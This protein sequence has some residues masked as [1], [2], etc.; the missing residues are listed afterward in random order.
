MQTFALFTHHGSRTNCKQLNGASA[1][2]DGGLVE[3][4]VVGEHHFASTRNNASW[5]R[6]AEGMFH[7]GLPMVSDS[8]GF[9]LFVH[10][11][12]D[13]KLDRAKALAVIT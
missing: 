7:R 8:T 2:F 5:C 13:A 12:H 6:D 10:L 3:M 11:E 1:Y 9:L 4:K